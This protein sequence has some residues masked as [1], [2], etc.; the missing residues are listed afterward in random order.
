MPAFATLLPRAEFASVLQTLGLGR[1]GPRDAFLARGFRAKSINMISRTFALRLLVAVGSLA[2]PWTILVHGLSSQPRSLSF[3][4]GGAEMEA[5]D[6]PE[7]L[8]PYHAK[9]IE[10]TDAALSVT[11]DTSQL[12]S[13]W[14]KETVRVS[15]GDA[16]PGPL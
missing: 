3:I 2:S 5:Q 1:A 13:G 11:S 15:F 16:R 8:H 4:S 6:L 10:M 7:F 9:S 14:L 12:L